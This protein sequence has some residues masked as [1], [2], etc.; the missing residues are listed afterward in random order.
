MEGKT[1]LVSSGLAPDGT[2][3]NISTGEGNKDYC[4][5]IKTAA[6]KATLPAF[7][8]PESLKKITA[9]NLDMNGSDQ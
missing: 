9:F 7:S 2:T 4:A 8:R 3:T 6:E 5:A 1:M